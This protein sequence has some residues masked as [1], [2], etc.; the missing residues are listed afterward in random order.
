MGQRQIEISEYTNGIRK[1]HG[2][3]APKQHSQLGP[4]CNLGPTGNAAWADSQKTLPDKALRVKAGANIPAKCKSHPT[5]SSLTCS[6][7]EKA[8]F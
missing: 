8:F 2:S 6:A 4:S 7:I 3:G 5:L 1:C